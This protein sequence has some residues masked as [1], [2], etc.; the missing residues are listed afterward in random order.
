M[1]HAESCLSKVCIPFLRGNEMKKA[2]VVGQ[3]IG[4]VTK[5]LDYN[6]LAP[7]SQCLC[8]LFKEMDSLISVAYFMQRENVKDNVY[9]VF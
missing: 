6:Q 2:D 8:L 7:M 4:N 1:V 3:E 5:M 9:A